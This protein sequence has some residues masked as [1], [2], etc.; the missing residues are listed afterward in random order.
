MDNLERTGVFQ[1]RGD[2]ADIQQHPRFTQVNPDDTEFTFVDA[3]SFFP[4]ITNEKLHGFSQGRCCQAWH[5]LGSVPQTRDSIEGVRFSLWAPN[6]ER[7]SVVSDFNHW[8][9]RVHPM[10]SLGTSG[11]WELF[12]PAAQIGA[13]Y[14]YEIRNRDSGKLFIK[15][16][17]YGQLYETPPQTASMVAPP[18]SHEWLDQPWLDDRAERDWLHQPMSIYELHLGSWRRGGD[19]GDQAPNYRDIATEL[20]DYVKSQRFTHIQ[21]MPVT[22]HPF[23]GS[24]GYQT[25]GY[26]APTRRYGSADDLRYLV[27]HCHQ[28]GIGVFLDWVPGHFPRDEHA[29]AFFDGTPLYEHRDPQRGEH[30]DWGTLIFDYG[31]N[32]VK[33]FLL[34]SAWYWLSEFHFDGLRVDAVASMLYLDYSRKHGEWS[35]NEYG[36]NENLEAI[37]FL[38]QVNMTMHRDFPGALVMAEESTAWPMVSRPVYVGGLG[39]SLKWNMGWMNDTL[40]YA[41]LDPIYRQY[42][43]DKLTFSLLYAYTENFILPL[44][45]DEVVHGKRS[46]L[47]KMPGD[48]WQQ[49]A[50]LRLLFTW[51]FTHPGNKLLFMGGEFAQENEWNHNQ[52]LDWDLTGSPGHHGM[53][54]LVSDLNGLYRDYPALHQYD[55]EPKGFDWLDCH[56]NTQSILSYVRR[57]D[58]DFL[59]VL[60]NFTPI[61]RNNYLVPIPA[62][63][64]YRVIFNSDSDVYGGS[65]YQDPTRDN[66][67]EMV[68]SEQPYLTQGHS[69]SI[70]LPPLAGIILQRLE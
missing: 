9:G 29:L 68:A 1:W 32:E 6:A 25:T 20:V 22:E 63:G 36:G 11:V 59:A 30:K 48:R 34:S 18:S 43:H 62:A 27:D 23:D 24:W 31:R 61:P 39:F 35:P 56:D 3:Y 5:Y 7:I 33:S 19:Q 58:D 57:S 21:F 54:V 10:K 52:Q 12:I 2:A 50:N 70:T 14:K 66:D 69:L 17:P 65:N 13:C 40:A 53:Q 4:Q 41:G 51:F 15:A 26:F 28:N 42:N 60:L 8:D 64:K 38:R 45:H 49:L 44:S 37:D 47:R 67:F 46:L 16:D 55:F